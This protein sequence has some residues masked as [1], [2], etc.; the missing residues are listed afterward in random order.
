L[1]TQG[2]QEETATTVGVDDLGTSTPLES[3]TSLKR[4]YPD[5][6]VEELPEAA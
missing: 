6:E 1:N 3:N 4:G 2:F 5:R